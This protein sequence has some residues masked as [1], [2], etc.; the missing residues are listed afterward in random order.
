MAKNILSKVASVIS[1]TTLLLVSNVNGAKAIVLFEHTGSADPTTEGW[2]F[3]STIAP[4]NSVDPVIN[5][6][7]LGID[8]WST[9]DNSTESGSRLLYSQDTNASLNNDALTFGWKLS[10]NLR[11]IDIPDDPFGSIVTGYRN[12]TQSFQLL[13]GSDSNG[14]VIVTAGF[15]TIDELQPVTLSGVSAN[16]YH[17]YELVFEPASNT[18]DIFLDGNLVIADYSGFNLPDASPSLLKNAVFFGSGSSADTGQANWNS[19]S[20]EIEQSVPEPSTLLG[21]GLAL[22]LGA[23]S[24]NR[25]Q[26]YAGEK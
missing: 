25:K 19:V 13:V 6:L 3:R 4:G 8:A 17:L 22:G 21:L 11:V 20:F 23:G 12:E 1:A 5:D 26:K 24:L 2:T 14:D 16:E 18:A 9:D 15:L 7:G 10:T